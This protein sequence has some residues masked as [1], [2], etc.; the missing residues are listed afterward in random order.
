MTELI[1]HGFPKNSLI[2]PIRWDEAVISV[3]EVIQDK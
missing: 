1:S 2:L 3:K